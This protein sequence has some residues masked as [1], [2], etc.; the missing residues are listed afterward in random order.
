[1]P[2]GEATGFALWGC[3][4]PGDCCVSTVCPWLRQPSSPP[5]TLGELL[6]VPSGEKH[7][8]A[9][10]GKTFARFPQR[11]SKRHPVS[12]RTPG[13]TSPCLSDPPTTH[14]QAVLKTQLSPA[15]LPRPT[16][17]PKLGLFQPS[18]PL[19]PSGEVKVHAASNC[20]AGACPL[21][22]SCELCSS[23]LP[24]SYCVYSSR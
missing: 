20:G 1:M 5:I 14:T 18:H 7:A 23:N 21:D 19:P 3:G 8:E 13:R 12:N 22:L 16:R 4:E 9:H 10:E 17:P 24:C 6:P 11:L 2:G 15:C